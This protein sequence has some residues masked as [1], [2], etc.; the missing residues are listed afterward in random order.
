ARTSFIVKK[1]TPVDDVPDI[2][3]IN[4]TVVHTYR[5]QMDD[6]DHH[7]VKYSLTEG[8]SIKN[9]TADNRAKTLSVVIDSTNGG[10]LTIELPRILID[11]LDKNG[12]DTKYLVSRVYSNGTMDTA[13]FI[14]ANITEIERTLVVNFG[15]DTDLIVVTG[16]QVIPEFGGLH[17]T[18][19]MASA[20]LALATTYLVRLRNRK[21]QP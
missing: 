8:N 7:D 1:P 15:K 20:S 19:L 13:T 17:S 10:T 11:S 3:T 14:E 5:V 4:K 9:M 6:G 21:S 16:T 18:A 2:I 12:A